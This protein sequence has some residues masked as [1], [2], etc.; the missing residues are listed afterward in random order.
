[1]IQPL[2]SL[3]IVVT[4]MVGSIVSNRAAR[5][6]LVPTVALPSLELSRTRLRGA[7]R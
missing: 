3:S 7:W 4:S 2:V 5:R 6:R 1:M